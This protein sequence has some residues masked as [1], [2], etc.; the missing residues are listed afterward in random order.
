M[1]RFG[2]IAY[3][4]F[5]LFLIA[6][7]WARAQYF[8]HYSIEDGLSDN[9]IHT[10]FKDKRGFIWI[11]TPN[12]LNR[13]D[14]YA[15]KKYYHDPKDSTSIPNNGTGSIT[16]DRDGFIWIGL[17]G[18]VAKYDYRTDRFAKINLD[19]ENGYDK[20]QHI[21]C[22][23]KNRIWIATWLGH[24]VF[25]NNGTL[26]KHWRKRDAPG[27][28]H[29]DHSNYTFQDSK[30]R[31]WLGN[32]GGISLVNENTLNLT[33]Y[34]NNSPPYG[35]YKEW[36]NDALQT[37]EDDKG[38]LWFGG[39]ANGL[40]CFNPNTGN[41]NTYIPTPEFLG[42]GAFNIIT[43]QQFFDG[44]LWIAC[45]D[46]GLGVFDTLAK[47]FSFV[48]DLKLEGLRLPKKQ[49]T[50]LKV[51]DN[52]LWVSSG[53]GLY[54]LD[55]RQ[56]FFAIHK[57]EGIRKGS[58]LPDITE[59][60]AV[61]EQNDKLFIPSWTCGIFEYNTKTRELKS[62]KNE[63]IDNLYSK[64]KIDFKKIFFDSRD[65]M[66]APSSHA[67][68]RIEKGKTI[69]I[70]PLPHPT[71]LP[72]ENY[73]T[74]VKEDPDGNIW[75]GSLDGIF[76]FKN[77]GSNYVKIKL[78][79]I[80][81]S[82]VNPVSEFINDL[83]VT[84]NGDIWFLRGEDVDPRKI[85]FSVYR[86]KTNNFETYTATEGAFEKYPFQFA[87][88][89]ILADNTGQIW[90]TSPRGVIIFK[91]G[92][93]SK[94]DYMTSLHGLISDRC[95]SIVQDSRGLVWISSP[96]GLSCIEPISR[97]IRNYTVDDGLPPANISSLSAGENGEMYIGFNHDWMAIFKP[98]KLKNNTKT[99]SVK[100]TAISLNNKSLL[101]T[102]TIY[103]EHDF[104]F[105]KLGFSPLNFLLPKNNSYSIEINHDGRIT[106]YEN[107][108]NEIMLS[109]LEPGTHQLRISAKDDFSNEISDP[110]E[111][112]FIVRPAFWQTWWFKISAFFLVIIIAA[113][114][115]RTRFQRL[116]KEELR[117][118]ELNKKIAAAEMNALRAQMNPHF[119]FNAL[120]AVHRFIWE[121][122]PNEASEY[123]TKFA[124]L[125]RMVLENS[126]EHWVS[127][128]EDLKA[129]EYYLQLEELNLEFGLTYNFKIDEKINTEQVLVP[130]LI[131]QPFVENALKHGLKPKPER[132]KITITIETKG[133]ELICTIDDDG[134][135]RKSNSNKIK[136][137]NS[138]GTQITS[139]RMDVINSLKEAQASFTYTDKTSE[140][141]ESLGTTVTLHL[142]LVLDV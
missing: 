6:P 28:L 130:P 53:D 117:I 60:A 84:P 66:W 113:W 126:R 119:I 100:L 128:A 112:I 54:K 98:Q 63:S 56:Q 10:V 2:K 91:D 109:G 81:K 133:N 44:K 12:G 75:A 131:L 8:E 46:K 90:V 7:C 86:K 74:T 120:N 57:L 19:F 3:Y 72:S 121:K 139:D 59:I 110:T 17:W 115:I 38:R 73:F 95:N 36:T 51:I 14:G 93:Y 102:D 69:K 104:N 99:N 101:P 107:K 15:F 13:Y 1:L 43:A 78:D 85:G 62:F 50:N 127:L 68:F 37:I 111:I 122:K 41:F 31:I 16:E 77:G 40:R 97:K 129:L 82:G 45:H 25:E 80:D 30:G 94:F 27:S 35:K 18:G 83:S 5:I 70:A 67:L 20:V 49:I 114:I 142:P 137:H 33:V 124:R 140:K 47:K 32:E 64:W 79:S 103:A 52:I 125:T 23:T 55:L 29:H 136:N 141:G 89:N 26:I 138:L 76:Y 123:L 34:K 108:N 4:I 71:G 105:L 88:S 134:V 106:K 116:K 132:G 9:T 92:D 11:S 87:G 65:V 42:E 61:P 22:D 24:Y 48:K 21:F 135:G 58:C 96:H 39:W 118:R